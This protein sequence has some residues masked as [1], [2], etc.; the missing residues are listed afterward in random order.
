MQIHLLFFGITRDL[1][2]KNSIDF[3][4]PSK[5]TVKTFKNTLLKTF[6]KLQ[7]H[8]NFS[9]AVNESYVQDFT[10]LKENDVVAIIPPVS[11]G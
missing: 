1:V 8:N 6:P 3:T 9:I 11:G 4:I 2:A 10:V 5:S 7:K